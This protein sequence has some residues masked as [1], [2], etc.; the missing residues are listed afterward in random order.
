MRLA[1]FQVKGKDG[2]AA[3]V[4]VIPLPGLA[5]SDLDNVNRWRRQVGLEPVKEEDMV[6]LGEQVEIA[7]QP[8]FLFD[9]S[10]QRP[11]STE[12][13]RILAALQR[14]EGVAWFFKMTGDPELIGA[15]KAAFVEL[16]KS[17]SFPAST[18]LPPGHP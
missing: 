2:K 17:F 8:G 5:G 18:G 14:R 3:D 1:S 16:L 15:Q 7:G 9:L 11:E 6:K 13:A 12:K 4:S 10:G